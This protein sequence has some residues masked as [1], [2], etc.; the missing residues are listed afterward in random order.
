MHNYRNITTQW[1]QTKS[2][3]HMTTQ[4]LRQI[5]KHNLPGDLT[6]VAQKKTQ[7]THLS[8]HR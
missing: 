2:F 1:M 8:S 5:G 4:L 3:S 6:A 7:V